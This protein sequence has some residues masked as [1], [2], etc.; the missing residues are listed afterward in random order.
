MSYIKNFLEN[1]DF[2]FEKDIFLKE[3]E[4]SENNELAGKLDNNVFV[5]NSP[6]NTNSSFYII[7]ALNLT[8]DEFYE[9]RK[10]I[11]NE[12]KYDFYFYPENSNIISLYYAKTNPIE[13][14]EKSKI[15]SFKGSDED[16]EKLEKIREWNFR[17]GAFWLSYSD[18]LNKVKNAERVDK[19]L[20]ERLIDLK[21][22]LLSELGNEKKK[23]VQTLIDRTLFIKFL[24]DNHIINSVFYKHYFNI[25]NLSYKELLNKKD[26]KGINRL[27][28]I[29][30]E[31][32][33]NI[34]FTSPKIDE[35]YI[36][37]ASDFIYSAISG[38]IEG[39]LSL[40]DFRFDIIPIEF[41]SH[42][43]EVFLED[44]RAKE[45]IYYT[46]PKLAQLIIDD[47]I[48][49]KG[50]VLDPACGSGMF[51]ILAFRKILKKNQPKENQSVSEK[52][53]TRINL[54]KN[55]IFGIEKQY[56]AWRLAIFS[57][58]LET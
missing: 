57:L 8:N 41:I 54:L 22:E 33:D 23:E 24:E 3:M 42:I 35:Q 6:E 53:E 20:I 19:K 27:F 40:F 44:I 13:N 37:Y 55:N 18:F 12:D 7:T 26:A 52:I 49:K 46:P 38:E 39:Q 15:D 25:E 21:K 31:I 4:F 17:T 16:V 5:Y 43:Y 32:F 1:L 36:I 45:G 10:Y 48:T 58:Y 30:N 9:I 47:T 2:S 28:G 29:I 34:L 50:K 51:L 56:T 14:K 11:W